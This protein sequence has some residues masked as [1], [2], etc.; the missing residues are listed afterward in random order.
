LF[1]VRVPRRVGVVTAAVVGI[2][3]VTVSAYA[4]ISAGASTGGGRVSTGAALNKVDVAGP[5]PIILT[6]DQPVDLSG[7]IVNDNTFGISIA[8]IKVTITGIKPV[9]QESGIKPV[10]PECS[11]TPGVNFFL[12]D[13]VPAPG[14]FFTAPG[15]PAPGIAGIGDW[16]GGKIEFR[17]SPDFDQTACLNRTIT[18][19]YTAV[20][21]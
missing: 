12:T 16:Q 21:P 6:L 9:T 3:A 14:K 7:S 19:R 10:T 13:A 1:E 5:S 20:A 15:S 17:S 8:K 2:L 11:I 18:L 4:W